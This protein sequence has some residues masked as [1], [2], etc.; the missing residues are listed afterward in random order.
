VDRPPV[1]RGLGLLALLWTLATAGGC[2]TV[3]PAVGP[4]SLAVG[5][6]AFRRTVEAYAAAPVVDGNR[7]DILLNGDQLFPAVLAAV[8][9]ARLSVNYAQYY[10][11]RGAIGRL[12]ADA[13]ADRCRSG[14]H[15]NLLLDA[16][17]AIGMPDAHRDIL[18]RSGCRL[19]FFHPLTDLVHLDQRN[20][21]RILVVDG[22][23]GF[24]GGWGVGRRWTGDGREPGHWRE[25]DARVEGPIVA[26]LQALFVRTWSRVT[27]EVLGGERYFPPLARRGSVALQVV[28]SDPPRG[29]VSVRTILLLAIHAARRSILVTT[30]YFVPDDA[31]LD[32]LVGAVARG[33]RVSLL[34][35]GPI[36]WNIARAA[37]R[38]DYGRLLRAGLEIHEYAAGLLHAKTLV[39][40][41]RWASV[42][43]ANLDMRSLGINRELD[44]AIY[45]QHTAAELAS[46]FQR[47]LQGAH[48]LDLETWRAR[49]V[50]R[51]L[52]E[53]FA[54]PVRD[55][56]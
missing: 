25:T 56:L 22:A 34:L 23:I 48:R 33:V 41:E 26:L 1:R 14:V 52:F 47:D 9:G 13:L 37:G 2:A 8:R 6:P 53:L 21:R 11:D 54:L 3:A 15:V 19:V 5:E 4:T 43:S 20:H 10:W 40:D 17:G 39:V 50:W 28:A 45:D 30:P 27:G 31:L 46:V 29:N 44:L 7:V 35:A 24:T 18:E 16:V 32:A 55:L 42:G 12:L 36:D 49:P 51:R 38:H